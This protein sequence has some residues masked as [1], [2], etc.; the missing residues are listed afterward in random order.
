MQL[1]LWFP[2]D[3]SPTEAMLRDPWFLADL[4]AAVGVLLYVIY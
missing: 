4:A 2:K 3:D 1:A